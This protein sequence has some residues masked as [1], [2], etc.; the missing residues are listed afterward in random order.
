MQVHELVQGSAAWLAHRAQHFNASDAPAMMG[1]SSYKTRSA[2]VAELATGIG[3][4]I[5]PEKQRLFDNGHRGEGLYRPHA[6]LIIGEPLYPVTGSKG[7]LS[8]SFDGITLDERIAFEHKS[9]NDRLRQAF[10][11]MGGDITLGHLLPPEYRV[12]MEQQIEVSGCEKVLF[13]ASKWDGEGNLVEALY[14]WYYPDPA[15]REQLIAG[16]AQLEHDVCSYTPPVSTS[17]APVAAPVQALPFVAVKVEG[18]LTV[19]SNLDKFETALR[20]FIEHRLIREPQT[21]QDFADLDT[22][23]K[24]MKGAEAALA[25]TDSNMLAQIQ[26]VDTALKHSAMLAKLV[27]DNRLMAEKL[28]TSEKDRRRQ[29]IV[30]KGQQGLRDHITALNDRLGKP[31]MPTVP[32]DFAA[33]V[34]GMRNISNMEEAVNTLLVNTKLQATAIADKID[35]NLKFLREHAANHAFLFSDASAIVQKAPEDL[36]LLVRARVAEHEAE[37]QRKQEAERERIRAEEAARAEREAREDLERRRRAVLAIRFPEPQPVAA[38]VIASAPA[39]TPAPLSLVSANNAARAAVNAA[40]PIAQPPSPAARE[41]TWIKTSDV[42]EALGL[43]VNADLLAT[44]GYPGTK[45]AGPGMWWDESRLEDIQAALAVHS[46]KALAAYR[47]R[48]TAAA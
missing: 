17:V 7:K 39:A 32:A 4:E 26:P 10:A 24:A 48:E 38:P 21:D 19:S 36:Q 37:Q 33:A 20:D 25:A 9:L 16:W 30:L 23:I 3:E 47:A 43:P 5:T 45:R 11:S 22:Q 29:E 6:E 28:L 18:E 40:A 12:Q 34:K 14:C 13:A 44:V 8:A 2:L 35:A 1:C 46:T 15:L 31:Y 27:R 42:A 41:V